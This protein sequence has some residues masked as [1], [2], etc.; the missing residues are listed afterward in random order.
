M[1]H[2]A[3]PASVG[4]QEPRALAAADSL[5]ARLLPSAVRA[6]VIASSPS[7]AVRRA[8]VT[9]AEARLAA[10]G[11]APA[12]L[13]SVESED[14][15]NARL[16]EGSTRLEVSREFL[17]GARRRT[18]RAAAETEVRLATV[19][20]AA[21]ER[22]AL[23]AAARAVYGAAGWR[24]IARRLGAQDSLLASAEASVRARFGVGEARY[25]DVLR[26]RTERLRVQTDRAVAETEADASTIALGTLVGGDSAAL[27]AAVTAVD[28]ADRGAARP[29]ARTVSRMPAVLSVVLPE[30]PPIDSL[31]GLAAD[32]QL[33]DARIAQARAQRQLVLARQRPAFSASLGIQR[34]G[35]DGG[36]GAGFGPVLSAGMTLPFTAARGNRAALAAAEQQTAVAVTAR[37]AAA[38]SVRGALAAARARYE[39][40]RRR[41]AT[42]DATLL[43]AAREERESA[44]AAYRTTDI[45]LLE[46]LDFE[47]ALARAEIERTQATLDAL[48]ALAELLSGA[49]S[50][51]APVSS[52]TTQSEAGAGR[53]ADDR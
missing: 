25:V 1:V 41:A 24:A 12:A 15:R 5:V 33:A 44:L 37:G 21:E 45:S 39:A 36:E 50:P 30:A 7:L 3:A 52:P 38:A 48:T 27:R 53:D 17:S 26:L 11:F 42:F 10:T 49:P 8:E 51:V 18:E 34:I 14:A 2:L 28:S 13:L 31:L 32:V 46:L 16:H 19:A 47:R 29:A 4:A 20:L 6:A 43:Q 35:P 40:A 23:A 9:A 22:R